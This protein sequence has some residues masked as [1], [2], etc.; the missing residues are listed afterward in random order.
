[1]L[2]PT[3]HAKHRSRSMVTQASLYSKVCA[4]GNGA[5]VEISSVIFGG[6]R[7]PEILQAG[8]CRILLHEQVIATTAWN[9]C[10]HP[11]STRPIACLAVSTLCP[12]QTARNA[13]CSRSIHL[14]IR[15]WGQREAVRYGEPSGQASCDGYRTALI[16]VLLVG[17]VRV[18]V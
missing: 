18:L 10:V 11:S 17:L 1:M 9:E 16:V 14:G 13:Q 4:V 5:H 8:N 6:R 12:I 3:E 15:H 7:L 2:Y